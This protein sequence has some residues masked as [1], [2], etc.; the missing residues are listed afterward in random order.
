MKRFNQNNHPKKLSKK[1]DKAY[2]T[3]KSELLSFINSTL[4]LNIKSIEQTITGAIFC[5]LL[6]AAH[7]GT[8]KMNKVNWRTKLETEFISN[9]KIFQQS[10]MNNNIDKPIDINRLSKGKTQELIELLQW[11]YGHHISLGINPANYDAKKKRNG[12]DF[13]FSTEKGTNNI[14]TLN[15]KNIRDDLSQCSSNTNFRDYQ[16]RNNLK[17]NQYINNLNVNLRGD[18]FLT[19]FSNQKHID[20]SAVKNKNKTKEIDSSNNISSN[21]SRTLSSS[22]NNDHIEDNNLKLKGINNINNNA[23]NPFIIKEQPD[24]NMK[25]DEEKIL[26]NNLFEGISNID[27]ENIIEMEKSDGD[28]VL[29]LKMLIRKLRVNNIKFRNNLGNILNNTKREKDF[30]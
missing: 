7:P 22:S 4:D 10:L 9:F 20:Y 28:N 17:K 29:E 5:Q 11:L 6:D 26:N 18:N 16:M 3:S 25:E 24:E 14:N 1:K 15:N 13:I 23:T 30:S 21:Y 27:K 8:V 2:F 12:H 19:K